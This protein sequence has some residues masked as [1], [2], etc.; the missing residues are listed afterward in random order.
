MDQGAVGCQNVTCFKPTPILGRGDQLP[1]NPGLELCS[2]VVIHQVPQA[3]VQEVSAVIH[4]I[5]ER[6]PLAQRNI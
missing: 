6:Y 1:V 3:I 5:F 4:D 2:I